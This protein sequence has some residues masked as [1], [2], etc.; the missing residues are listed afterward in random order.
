MDRFARYYTPAV[1]AGASPSLTLA[2]MPLATTL[3]PS[4][5]PLQPTVT[6]TPV[7]PSVEV[8]LADGCGGTFAPGTWLSIE[9][10]SSIAGRVAIYLVDPGGDHAPLFEADIEPREHVRQAWIA[11]EWEGTWTVKAVLND[12]QASDQC[13]FTVGAPTDPPVEIQQAGPPQP[14]PAVDVWLPEGCGHTYEPGAYTEINLQANVP[15]Q[16]D[17]Y[18]SDRGG[19]GM[20]FL[21]NGTVQAG[22]VASRSWNMPEPDG[23]WSLVAVLNGGQAREYCGFT[24]ERPTPTPVQVDVELVNGCDRVYEPGSGTGILGSIQG[25]EST[26][27][28][29]SGGGG[30]RLDQA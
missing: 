21:F 11:P 1:I 18:L 24:V 4:S 16:V 22:Q 25:G 2:P 23:N 3:T 20:Q 27:L 6:P 5:T 12:G 9:A 28:G 26:G 19:G 14:A 15:G 30:G 8:W 10:R 17:V 29:G 7:Q 13:S